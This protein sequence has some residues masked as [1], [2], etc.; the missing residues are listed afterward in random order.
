VIDFIDSVYYPRHFIG[1]QDSSQYSLSVSV[2]SNTHQLV[3]SVQSTASPLVTS[4]QDQQVLLWLDEYHLQFP[5]D[6]I[7]DGSYLVGEFRRKNGSGPEET[8]SWFN[9]TIDKAKI[10]TD[11][12][13]VDLCAPPRVLAAKPTTVVSPSQ[14]TLEMEVIISKRTGRETVLF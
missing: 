8:L 4:V 11:V 7:V 5:L 13:K 14:S 3:E 6:N 1:A 12:L 2:F 9:I 10:D